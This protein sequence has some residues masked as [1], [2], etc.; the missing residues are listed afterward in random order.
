MRGNTITLQ[1]S[2]KSAAHVSGLYQYDYGQR[3]IISGPELPVAYEVHFSNQERGISK[4]MIGDST[5]V[6]I[7]DEYLL[8]GENIYVWMFLHDGETD[9]ETEYHGV[10]HVQRRAKPTDIEPTPVQQDVI[11]QTIA[12]LNAGVDEVER[13][14]EEIPETINEALQE[15]KD[16]GEFDGYSPS[17]TVTKE[18]RI[19]T[20]TI[21][22][23]DGTT[24]AT[25]TDP[26]PTDLIDDTAGE[27]VTD[28]AWS[29]DKLTSELDLKAPKDNPVFTGSISLGRK[30]DTVVGQQSY[31]VGNS[32]EANGLAAHAEGYQTIASTAA[33][34]EGMGT[35][36]YSTGAHAEGQYTYSGGNGSHAEGIMTAAVGTNSHAEG[37]G[38]GSNN[39]RITGDANVTTY[40]ISPWSDSL[41][42]SRIGALIAYRDRIAYITSFDSVNHTVTLSK[43]L[44]STAIENEKCLYVFGYASG[45]ISHVEGIGTI[46]NS[47]ITHASGRFNKPQD[48]YPAW[49]AR[50]AYKIGDRVINYDS[51]YECIVANNDSAFNQSKWKVIYTTSDTAFVIGNGEDHTNRSNAVTIDWD[52]NEYLMGDVYVGSDSNSQNGSKLAKVSELADVIAVQDQEPSNPL[53]EIWLPETQTETVTVATLDDLKDVIDDTAGDGDTEKTWSADKLADELNL[54]APKASPEFTGSIS[55]GR[56]VGTTV[57]DR[58]FAVGNNVEASGADSHVEGRFS[59]ATGDIAHAEGLTTTASSSYTHAE[60]SNTLASSVGAHAEGMFS[61]ASG[62]ASHSQ[63]YKTIANAN[64]MAASGIYNIQANIYPTWTA[65]TSYEV[66]DRV[67]MFGFQFLECKTANSD[68]TFDWTKWEEIDFSSDTLFVIGNGVDENH[69]SN[70]ME[71]DLHGNSR[72]AGDVY[73]R[74]NNDSTGGTK[75]ASL[76]DIPDAAT[77]EE[78]QLIIDAWDA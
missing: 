46:A 45:R 11:T 74:C 70:A 24:T 37:S 4:T 32:V 38:V 25:V 5:G 17:A 10:I 59:K 39:Y 54:K 73:V 36:S 61:T 57:G 9:G 67:S 35:V 64:F 26:D 63:G 3:L 21:T 62:I 65:G 22:D 75:L 27:G 50:T 66:G 42:D 13:I 14:A 16:S 47:G 60:G 51:G 68:E 18:G 72:L 58:S 1:M 56:K 29:A 33:H 28:R 34:A 71:V 12:A 30:E 15:A 2:E 8:T 44:S 53:T 69:R 48:L 77:L 76:D 19:A 7:P 20:I 43:T 40:T 23:K 52:G 78:T 31:A 41:N 55:L 6:D 49:K